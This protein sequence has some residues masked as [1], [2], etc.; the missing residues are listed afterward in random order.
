MN[1]M[2]SKV[3]QG[4]VSGEASWLRLQ[5][6]YVYQ[7]SCNCQTDKRADLIFVRNAEDISGQPFIHWDHCFTLSRGVGKRLR[8]GQFYFRK[9]KNT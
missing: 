6:D 5:N 2:G 7:Q 1:E 3:S 9:H 4:F 8:L